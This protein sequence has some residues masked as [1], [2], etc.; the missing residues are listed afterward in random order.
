MTDLQQL[1]QA[2][3]ADPD[4]FSVSWIQRRLRIGYAR[5]CRLRDEALQADM[6]VRVTRVSA[7]GRNEYAYAQ[8]GREQSEALEWFQ[9]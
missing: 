6:V 3:Q 7:E 4:A 5:A 1:R 9:A 2:L 8:P